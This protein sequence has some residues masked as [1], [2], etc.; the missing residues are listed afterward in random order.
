[1][2]GT[3]FQFV[4]DLSLDHCVIDPVSTLIFAFEDLCSSLSLLVTYV[5]ALLELFV[6]SLSLSRLLCSTLVAV[7]EIAPLMVR[8]LFSL[9]VWLFANK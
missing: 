7:T 5:F 1:M 9:N 6:G 2:D 8:L 4:L 3:L